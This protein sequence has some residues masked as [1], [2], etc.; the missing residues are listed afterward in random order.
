[1]KNKKKLTKKDIVRRIQH[2]RRELVKH[3][4]TYYVTFNNTIPDS[5]WDEMAYELV[6]LQKK[7]KKVGLW[8]EEFADWDG[9][10]GY[11]I[12]LLKEV[13]R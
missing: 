3:S 8:D 9:H 7:T 12:S 2:L 13:E 10:T 1:M 5:E 6:D 11:H 4:Y